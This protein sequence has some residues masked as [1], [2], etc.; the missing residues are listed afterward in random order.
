V[1]GRGTRWGDE[2]P[3]MRTRHQ[4]WVLSG[5]C[6]LMVNVHHVCTRVGSKAPSSVQWEQQ[7]VI[8]DRQATLPGQ[9]AANT[10]HYHKHTKK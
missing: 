1:G 9:K 3:D 7:R 10:P 6:Y 2:M 5:S 8:V 4:A